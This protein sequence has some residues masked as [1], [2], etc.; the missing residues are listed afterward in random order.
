MKI[1]FLTKFSLK[2]PTVIFLLIALIIAGGIYSASNLKSELM[3]NISVPLVTVSTFYP[4]ASPQDILDNVTKPLEQA[5]SGVKGVDKV[6]S[7][8]NEN[9]SMVMCQFDFSADM[10]KAEQEIQQAVNKVSLP[11]QVVTPKVGQITFGGFPIQ[12]YSFTG[13][14]PEK[15]EKIMTDNVKP[16]MEGLDGI[17]SVELT[18]ISDKNIYI[19]INADKLKE[20]N[21]TLDS[22]KQTLQANNISFPTGTVEI[23]SKTVP[24]RVSKKLLSLEDIRNIPLMS[25]PNIGATMGDAFSAI[26]EGMGQL[27][28]GLGQLGQSMGALGQALG[29]N[30]Q[31]TVLLAMIQQVQTDIDKQTLVINNPAATP[32]DKGAAQGLLMRDQQM[33]MS[34]RIAL[35]DWLNKAKAS[36]P[37][38]SSSAPKAKSAPKLNTDKKIS[39]EAKVK[40]VL[41]KDIAEIKTGSEKPS[42]YSRV[43]GQPALILSLSKT[44]DANT[45][46]VADKINEKLHELKKEYGDDLKYTLIMDQAVEINKSVKGMLR[47][48]MLGALF[49]VLVIALFLRNIRATMVAVVSIPL[50]MLITLLLLPKF[51]ITINMMSL[52]GMTIA[53][54]RV[55]DDSIVVIENIYRRLQLDEGSKGADFVGLVTQEVASAIT[56]STITTVAVFLPLGLVSGMIGKI[57]APFAVTVVIAILASLLVAV[58]VVPML[59]KL[60]LLKKTVHNEKEGLLQRYYRRLLDW[61]LRKRWAIVLISVGL[62]ALSIG[63]VK[64]VGVHFL[65]QDTSGTLQVSMSLKP[66]TS[67]DI[68]NEKAKAFEN[69]VL[70]NQAVKTIQT[71]VG[72]SNMVTGMGANLQGSNGASFMIIVKHSE[73]ADKVAEELRKEAKTLENNDV[74]FNVQTQNRSGATEQV[75]VIVNGSD[76]NTLRAAAEKIKTLMEGRSDVANITNNLSEEKPEVAIDVDA[77]K[78]AD[79]GFSPIMVAGIVRNMIT[80]SEASTIDQNGKTISIMLSLDHASLNNLN[81]IADLEITGMSGTVKLKEIATVQ[82]VK[83]PVSISQLDGNQY[84]SIKGDVTGSNTQ[85]VSKDILAMI[86]KHKAE[87]PTG[88][89]Y[90]MSGSSENI[91]ESFA[92]MGIA[93][94]VAIVMVYVVML[95]TFGE[96]I[97]PFSI[98]FALPFAAVGGLIGLYVS[99]QPIS[100]SSLIGILMLIGIV[101]TNAIVYIDRVLSNKASGMNTHDALLEAGAVRLRPILMTA[102]ATIMALLP[103]AAGASEGAL[104]SVGLGVTVI[105]GLT[106]STLL[107]LVVVPVAYSYLDQIRS[108]FTKSKEDQPLL[109]ADL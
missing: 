64:Q 53:I 62:M 79:K 29:T 67:L 103:L 92:Q 44:D 17:S 89:T 94:L 13:S 60:M 19:S 9:I 106:L 87:L 52:A 21:L 71:T 25:Q 51:N 2:N 16:A 46:E 68:T 6:T 102:I 14:S 23:D 18:G 70:S 30:A 55:V 90:Q 77:K 48:A 36:I 78:A 4:G 45:V 93:I 73:N 82:Q 11:E 86:D 22:V 76:I 65:P 24:V 34:Y 107:T 109:P 50:S 1:N 100:M 41:L 49:A 80:E 98:L 101:V 57:F 31:G 7:I 43:N 28:Q 69:K 75:E 40:V 84:A 37:K 95:V 42:S 26:G 12:I 27:G 35:N 10:D 3:P 105:G 96:A 104:I 5:V 38:G 15:L 97:A 59:S 88:I 81:K 85:Q 20:Y 72:S 91:N 99:K 33:I 58:T 47:E 108:F 63:L 39:T 56:S 83:G 54:G 66:G 8:S 61:S 74:K 32:A